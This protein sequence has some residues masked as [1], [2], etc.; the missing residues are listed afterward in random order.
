MKSKKIV[1]ESLRP[2]LKTVLE[3]AGDDMDRLRRA[4]ET[5][6]QIIA[7]RK[8]IADSTVPEIDTDSLSTT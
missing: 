5:M 8:P 7:S 1:S 2:D 3:W 4:L 6:E